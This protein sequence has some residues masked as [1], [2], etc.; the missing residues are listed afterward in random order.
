MNRVSILSALVI[1]IFAANNL[2]AEK[3]PSAVVLNKYTADLQKQ[4][5]M[6][7]ERYMARLQARADK[8][9]KQLERAET[10]QLQRQAL[11]ERQRRINYWGFADPETLISAQ[12][13]EATKNRIDGRKQAIQM[14]LAAAMENLEK[15]KVADLK[16][17]ADRPP[18]ASQTTTPQPKTRGLVT[19][20]VYSTDTPLILLDN[21]I[22]GEGES[23]DGV[24]IVKI[25]RDKVE[26]EKDDERW[27]QRIGQPGGSN[28]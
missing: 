3:E 28:W 7:C 6:Y 1:G 25:Q 22:C 19:G 12:K 23:K 9:I 14:K 2:S 4:I 15:K 10:Q 24:K 21:Q 26:F 17:L 18:K 20:I 13:Q 8:Q 11:I 27:F 16:R 5:E